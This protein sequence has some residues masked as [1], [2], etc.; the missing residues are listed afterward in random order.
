MIYFSPEARRQTSIISQRVVNKFCST[1]CCPDFFRIIDHCDHNNPGVIVL[2]TENLNDYLAP[3]LELLHHLAPDFISINGESTAFSGRLT[4]YVETNVHDGDYDSE[5]VEFLLHYF[6]I[7]CSKK[8]SWEPY[9]LRLTG[10]AVNIA[11]AHLPSLEQS[12]RMV[13]REISMHDVD[14]L[15]VKFDNAV[16]SIC[17]YL[18]RSE[19][20]VRLLNKHSEYQILEISRDKQKEIIVTRFYPIDATFADKALKILNDLEPVE[21]SSVIRS[22]LA[23]DGDFKPLITKYDYRDFAEYPKET[24]AAQNL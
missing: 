2:P 9:A 23:L 8:P 18:S 12:G 19:T 24:A 1:S 14:D 5:D 22:P 15:Q 21:L 20:I 16:L 6:D 11:Y 4:T 7:L 13:V 17:Q 10:D 3:P